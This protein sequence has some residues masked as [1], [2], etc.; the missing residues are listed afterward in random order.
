MEQAVFCLVKKVCY[1]EFAHT[2]LAVV[3]AHYGC[4]RNTEG[5]NQP[6]KLNIGH[7]APGIVAGKCDKVGLVVCNELSD[8]VLCVFAELVVLL[9]VIKLNVRK[10]EHDKVLTGCLFKLNVVVCAEFVFRRPVC[11][12]SILAEGGNPAAYGCKNLTQRKE[13]CNDK[14]ENCHFVLPPF[15]YHFTTFAGKP[16]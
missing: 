16:Q 14:S 5:V 8:A 15:F 13:A 12:I 11:E 4:P 1:P 7:C 6:D 2:A 10:V 3:I 9:V